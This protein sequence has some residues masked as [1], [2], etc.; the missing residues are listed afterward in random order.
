MNNAIEDMKMLGAIMVDPADLATHGKFGDTEFTVFLYE[1]K[2]GLNAYLAS[3]GGGAP[4]R[5][6]KEIIVFNERNR[7]K[8]MPYFGQDI[9]VRK[10]L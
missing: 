3:R 10:F 5:S 7:E 9:F 1:L 2:A 6:L 4:V 8:E